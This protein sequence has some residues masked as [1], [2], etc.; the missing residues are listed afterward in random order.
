MKSMIIIPTYNEINNIEKL[1]QSIYSLKDKFYIT[2]IDDNSPD[3]TGKA[4]DRLSS[5]NP[6]IHVIHRHKK[7]GLGSAYMH[8]FRY[9]LGKKMDYIFEMDADFS[10][11]PKYLHEMLEAIKE[12]DLV[13]GSRYY[14]G[15][16][17]DGWD[18]RRLLLSKIANLYASFFII[19]PMCDFTSGFRCYRRKVLEYI[20]FDTIRSDGYAFQIEMVTYAY[21][22]GFSIKEIPII[23]YGREH[24]NSKIS[25]HIV[26]EAIWTVI[27]LRSP[28]KD[29]INHLKLLSRNYFRQ[30]AD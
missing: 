3:G 1:V 22:L 13:I 4:A 6:K 5:E 9:A 23:F 16:R 21:R 26:W 14:Q 17:I 30:K 10:H 19:F 24:G 25:R 28:I 12:S 11:H 7:L 20:D 27:R 8:G 18:F 2:I 29:I 15:V